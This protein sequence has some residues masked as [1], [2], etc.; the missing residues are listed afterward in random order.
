MS[1]PAAKSA[2]MSPARRRRVTR[3]WKMLVGFT[4]RNVGQAFFACRPGFPKE[5]QAGPA[6]EAVRGCPLLLPAV[7]FAIS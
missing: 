7:R 5:S 1:H 4:L 3:L 6:R 2:A